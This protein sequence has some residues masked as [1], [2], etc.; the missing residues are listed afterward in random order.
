MVLTSNDT[1][2]KAVLKTIKVH[3]H[4]L[5]EK[6]VDSTE[7]SKYSSSSKKKVTHR[8]QRQLQL[9]FPELILTTKNL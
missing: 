3:W 1:C 7:L 9:L 8:A 4:R 6:C 2:F 5:K